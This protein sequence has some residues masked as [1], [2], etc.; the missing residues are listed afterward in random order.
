MSRVV[1]FGLAVVGL[2]AFASCGSRSPL[3][4]ESPDASIGS[5]TGGLFG[6]GGGTATGAGGSS[7]GG[8]IAGGNGVGGKGG[9]AGTFGAGGVAGNAGTF[10][11][12]GGVAGAA[13]TFGAGGAAGAAGFVGAGG[14]S[15][16]LGTGGTLGA[17][18]SAIGGLLPILPGI[19]LTQTCIDCVNR[20]C[21]GATACTSDPVC[22]KGLICAVTSCAFNG[23]MQQ[24]NIGCLLGC[25]SGSM[26]ALTEAA[27]DLLCVYGTCGSSCT[28]T[29]Q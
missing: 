13:G 20:A 29:Q 14:T 17:G 25:F 11:A 27:R 10:G 7:A 2:A 24:G 8:G 12:G 21:N 28:T 9:A 4:G 1:I 16:F 15:V 3:E 26:Q 18:G 19:R 5:G 22:F 6:R 23:T